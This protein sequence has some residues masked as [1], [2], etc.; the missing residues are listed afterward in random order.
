MA[1]YGYSGNGLGQF[2]NPQNV[3]FDASSNF[4]VADRSNGRIQKFSNSGNF[5][6]TMDSFPANPGLFNGPS[7]L[8]IDA[9]GNIYVADTNNNR[10]AKYSGAGTFLTSWGSSGSA[11]GQFSSPQ[12]IAID[13][14]GNVWVADSYNHR[15][16]KFNSLG[17]WLT[18][19]GSKGSL[20]GQ[21]NT[22]TGVAADATNVWVSDTTN[23][24]IQQLSSS[25]GAFI[26][27]FGTNGAGLGQF[28]N[29]SNLAID[30]SKSLFIADRSNGRIQVFNTGSPSAVK[31]FCTSNTSPKWG[32]DPVVVSGGTAGAASGDTVTIDW[33]DGKTTAGIPIA[34]GT[35]LWGPME[36]VYDATST[37]AK[38]VVAKVYNATSL[39]FTSAAVTVNVQKHKTFLSSTAPVNVPWGQPTSFPVTLTDTDT[40]KALAS[41]TINWTGTGVIAVANKV[42]D[43]TGKATG[44]GTA[45]NTVASGWTVIAHF[46]GDVSYAAANSSTQVYN[47]LPHATALTLSIIPSTVVHG[48]SYQVNG[49]LKYT[50]LN[51]ALASKAITF[52]ATSPI[53]IASVMTDG[54]GKYIKTGLVAPSAGSYTI[55]A[56]R[57]AEALYAAADSPPKT[58]TVT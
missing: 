11:D 2:S 15:V 19:L 35:G 18:S 31:I 51:V 30:S 41:K 17:K 47:T 20:N 37:G 22:P 58:L 29:P 53:T 5:L 45:P 26:S 16:V 48:G 46:A 6:F 42:T 43:S 13:G 8:A 34:A 55:T 50:T 14:S 49:T 38:S 28:S 3:A 1:S 24:R 10:V 36:H 40:G 57:V 25:T 33:G 52:T 56:H 32:L 27:A 39:R 4:Y 7:A 44:T 12:G 54:T 21:F 23:H 9:T